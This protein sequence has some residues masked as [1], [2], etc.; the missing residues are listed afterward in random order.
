MPHHPG[1]ALTMSLVRTWLPLVICLS[2]V[3]VLV[4]RGFDETG[5]EAV[6][7]LVAAGVLLVLPV[8]LAGKELIAT[9]ETIAAVALL[10]VL[11]DGYVAGVWRP[12][13][14]GIEATAFHRLPGD[15]WTGLAAEAV[16][17]EA[18]CGPTTTA[19]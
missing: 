13:E 17:T 5:W 8:V 2:G 19:P 4:L 18:P 7:V 9:A 12:V 6:T 14:A 3:A 16:S 10:M 11:V 1:H 15:A